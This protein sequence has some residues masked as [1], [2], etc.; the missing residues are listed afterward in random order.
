MRNRGWRRK[1]DFYK[2]IRKRKIDLQ[3]NSWD[4]TVYNNPIKPN[5]YHPN[6]KPKYGIYDNIHQYGKNKIHCSCSMCSAKTRNKGNRRL[7]HGNYYP[8]INYKISE[9]KKVDSMNY[10]IN[11]YENNDI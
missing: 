2:A 11:E 3:V 4:F 5:Y 10:K 6:Y 7:K 8:S 9:K 1:K